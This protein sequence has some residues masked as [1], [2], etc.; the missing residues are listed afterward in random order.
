M[1]D[2]HDPTPWLVA[3][4]LTLMFAALLTLPV[5]GLPPDWLLSGRATSPAGHLYATQQV[6]PVPRG[7]NVALVPHAPPQE[8][9]P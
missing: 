2:H 6:I 9:T 7:Y 4:L 3:A 8:D 5:R 1:P